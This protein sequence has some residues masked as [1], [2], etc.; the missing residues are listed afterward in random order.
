MNIYRFLLIVACTVL[1]LQGFAQQTHNLKE[2]LVEGKSEKDALLQKKEAGETK[3]VVSGKQI[4]SFG[5]HAAGD[6]LKRLP[7]IVVQGPP[8]FNRNIMMAGLEKEFQCVL[9]NG[10][11]PAGGEDYRD[12]KLDRLPVE[13]IE[14]I[15]V[16]MNPPVTMGGDATIGAVNVI[17]K[18]TPEKQKFTAS[19][20]LDNSSTKQSLNPE[21]SLSYG[22]KKGKWSFMGTADVNSFRRQNIVG[23]EDSEAGIK[24]SEVEDLDVLIKGFSGK[25]SYALDSNQ[26]FTLSL[27]GTDYDETAAFVADAKRR[28]Q[29]GL[30]LRADTANNT[31]ERKLQKESLSY[32]YK[33]GKF[34]FATEFTHAAHYDA[35]DRWRYQEKSD[36]FYTVYEDEFQ[37]NQELILDNRLK[38]T[39]NQ[40]HSLLWGLNGS[41]LGRTF[42]RM[43]YDKGR[44]DKFWVNI[45]D[46]SYYLNE[47]LVSSYVG[48]EY[49]HKNFWISPAV[50]VDNNWGHYTTANNREGEI[51]YINLSP[52][53]HAKYKATES[54]FIKGDMAR[55][56]SRPPFNLMVPVD[57]IKNKK[58]LIE[59]GNADL[60]PSKSHNI[61]GSVEKYFANKGFASARIYGSYINDAIESKLIGKDQSTG[62]NIF[63]SVN[64]DTGL[65]WGIDL[66][67]QYSVEKG[68]LQG[69]SVN[70]NASFLGSQVRDAGTGELRRIN[71]QPKWMGN[72]S[73]DY[74]N[75]KM[76]FQG[77]IGVHVIGSREISGT[78]DDELNVISPVKQKP[79]AQFDAR[80]KY[81]FKPWGSVYLN[82]TNLFDEYNHRVQGTV[83]EKEYIG[84]NIIIG[85]NL[86]F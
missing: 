79:F 65:V 62:Y 1:F 44:G 36:G 9:I 70:G 22:N 38:Y 47:N 16:I 2:I 39:L 30:N 61:T 10:K 19:V 25:V 17:L 51:N 73:F 28:T 35:K 31:K 60:K 55:Q 80:I 86:T 81:F 40:S 52:S 12:F 45:I 14:R 67:A 49:S 78:I 48:Y 15:E 66:S 13:M 85:A 24:G 64:V 34:D 82:A 53:L 84:R 23:L 59:R 6:V 18:E 83:T 32:R 20:S 50:R 58:T 54:F 37:N 63:Q 3:I 27:L 5:H 8:G 29:G 76:K 7:G 11:R 75:T 71:E 72:F 43:A 42:D 57:K 56:I 69:I 68:A 41:W 46:G 21:F 77:S 26:T 33:K 4:N 74:I